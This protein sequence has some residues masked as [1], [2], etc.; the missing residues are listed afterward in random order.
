M[1]TRKPPSLFT[2][3]HW[4]ELESLEIQGRIEDADSE[5]NKGQDE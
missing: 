1:D 4:S 2:P 3:P 5:G